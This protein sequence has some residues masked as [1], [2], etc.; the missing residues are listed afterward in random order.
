MNLCWSLDKVGPICRTVEDCA[1]VLEAIRGSDG[2]DHAVIDAPFNYRSDLDLRKIR[3]GYR[4][5]QLS[6][7]IV[8]R[9]A[10]I[11]GQEQM[12]EVQLPA[13]SLS[14][15]L[16]LKVESA[17]SFDELTRFGADAYVS[18]VLQNTFSA[19]RAVPAVEYLQANRVRKKLITSMA[20]LMTRIDVYVGTQAEV[21]E[22]AAA[23]ISNLTGHPCV[24]IPHG[25]ATSLGFIGRPFAEAT[26]LALAKAYQ[27][28]TGFHTNRPP[29]FVR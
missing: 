12:V 25:G 3:V 9:L 13:N 17:A 4:R 1:I 15:M 8:N 28:A 20:E 26:I 11:V 27:D 7:S 16:I 10:S 5:G 19:G 22:G 18:G 2:I 29:T 14:L 21:L 23:E 6:S 24:A